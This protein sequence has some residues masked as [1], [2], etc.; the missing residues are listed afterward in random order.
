MTEDGLISYAFRFY[1]NRLKQNRFKNQCLAACDYKLISLGD[2]FPNFQ[3]RTNT[4]GATITAWEVYYSSDDTLYADISSEISMLDITT[5]S[6]RD[7][8]TY[9]GSIV[10]GLSMN[11]GSF[12]IRIATSAEEFFSEVFCV[13]G[14]TDDS[15]ITETEKPI[16]TAWRYYDNILKS[17]R[18]RKH[19]QNICDFYL[20]CGNDALLN[21]MFRIPHTANNVVRWYLR[22]MDE[23]CEHELD[24]NSNIAKVQVG[25]YD[26]IYYLGGSISDLPCGKYISIITIG[27]QDY[28]SEP[29]EIINSISSITA[30]NY[31]LQE[32]GDK[33]LQETGSG[34]LHS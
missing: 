14:F 21:F 4:S 17:E 28:F 30:T 34:I 16:F 12:Y 1:D 19:C 18:Y 25:S 22:D 31:L 8:I 6:Y 32:T 23:T 5:K 26:Y 29:I 24:F 3:F 7:Y 33:I 27:S 2:R 10:S 15:P 9:D 11:C 20:I 13:D